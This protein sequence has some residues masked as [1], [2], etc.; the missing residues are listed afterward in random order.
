MSEK[1]E[2]SRPL[3]GLINQW[4]GTRPKECR[5]ISA[6]RL[7]ELTAADVFPRSIFCI[8]QF[9][10]LGLSVCAGHGLC[11]C[12]HDVYRPA[13]LKLSEKKGEASSVERKGRSLILP[14]DSKVVMQQPGSSTSD[15]WR[16]HPSAG[17]GHQQQ[18]KQMKGQVLHFRKRN[19]MFNHSMKKT[20]SQRDAAAAAA[21]QLPFNSQ[22]AIDGEIEI[23]R[24]IHVLSLSLFLADENS[25]LLQTA[26]VAPQ[27]ALSSGDIMLSKTTPEK[28]FS[29]NRQLQ[30]PS[31]HQ[32]YID[33]LLCTIDASSMNSVISVNSH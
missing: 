14:C 28:N 17:P 29:L 3:S 19:A 27:I 26:P 16:R 32:Y 11:M 21:D 1:K 15:P 13:L 2:P 6:P 22:D 10:Q 12:T 20:T 4:V 7:I 5:C 23:F 25:G 33:A 24:V 18:E 31:I 8:K 30:G 9:F